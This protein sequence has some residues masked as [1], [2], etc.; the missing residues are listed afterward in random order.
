MCHF[1]SKHSIIDVHSVRDLVAPESACG[2]PDHRGYAVAV[3]QVLGVAQEC[4]GGEA[5]CREPLA[6]HPYFQQLAE[7]LEDPGI[8]DQIGVDQVIEV[9]VALCRAEWYGGVLERRLLD[10]L[11]ES[12]ICRH[13]QLSRLDRSVGGE[14]AKDVIVRR[15]TRRGPL[16]S[17][18]ECR[19]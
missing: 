2:S 13:E 5:G 12:L 9:E 7:Y 10:R 8:L 3:E 11:D 1:D 18:L 17:P 4:L 6:E 14:I 15:G 19:A 16:G